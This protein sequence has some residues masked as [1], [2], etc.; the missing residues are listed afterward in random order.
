MTRLPILMYHNVSNDDKDS[1]GLTIF[2]DALENQFRYLNQMGFCTYHF[3]ELENVTSIHSKSVIITFDDITENQLLHA[4]PLLQKYNLKATFFI[5]FGYIGDADIWNNGKEKIMSIDQLKELDSL[6]E[7]GLHSF[8]HR[9]Y[10]TLTESELNVDFFKCFEVIEKNG[11]KVYNALAY[12]YGNYP[13]KE[14]NKLMFNTVL[15]QNNIKAGLRIGNRINKF[16]FKNPYEIMRIDI[17]GED[18]L[19]KFKLKLRFGKLKLF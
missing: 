11:L 15:E 13:K 17:K 14:P 3:S 1:K 12:P 4:V 6:V 16:P 18:S 8:E 19:L 10:A 9:K 5:P 2:C 7:L